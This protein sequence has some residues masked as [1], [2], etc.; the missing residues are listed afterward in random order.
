MKRLVFLL[1]VSF[2]AFAQQQPPD[3][4][5]KPAAERPQP[6]SAAAGGTALAPDDG[7]LFERLDTN[8][9]GFLSDAELARDEARQGNWIALDRNGDGRISRGEFTGLSRP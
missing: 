8:R 7:R 4:A 9:D 3:N 2:P 5:A 1:L 6:R